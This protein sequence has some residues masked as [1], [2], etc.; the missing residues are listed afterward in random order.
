MRILV[1]GTAVWGVSQAATGLLLG[2]GRPGA[3]STA[4]VVA[5]VVTVLGVYPAVLVAGTRGA[6]VLAVLAYVLSGLVKLV[7]LRRALGTSWSELLLTRPS[8]LAHLAG[9]LRRL[10][11]R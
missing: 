6:A 9:L 11:R 1:V 8:D 10:V 5:G 4:D 7:V 3:S 2:A